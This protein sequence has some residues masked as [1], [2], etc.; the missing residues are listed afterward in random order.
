[1]ERTGWPKVMEV[2][3]ISLLQVAHILLGGVLSFMEVLLI[4]LLEATSEEV[5]AGPPSMTSSTVYK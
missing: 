4:P 2:D 3:G 1:M 5:V